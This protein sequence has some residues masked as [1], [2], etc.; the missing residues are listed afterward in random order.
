M[1]SSGLARKQVPATRAAVCEQADSRGAIALDPRAV[2]RGRASREHA[3]FLVDPAERRDVLVRAEQD[4][5]LAGSRLRREIGLPL[6][7][8]VRPGGDPAGHGR[9][10][11]V[12]HRPAEYG[13]REPIDLEEE[14]SRHV[15]WARPALPARD[16]LHYSQRVGVVV[17][18][19]E[20]HLE[21]DAHGGDDQRRQQRPPEVVDDEGVLENVRCELQR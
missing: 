12:A 8:P 5:G 14:D 9:R 3:A 20:D 2:V 10:V 16:A 6:A 19:A 17:I 15:G 11:A 1:T 13:K 18:R 21:R 7:Q 4:P